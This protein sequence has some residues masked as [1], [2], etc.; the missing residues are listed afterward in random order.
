MHYILLH[1]IQFNRRTS[2]AFPKKE[3]LLDMIN[4]KSR[5]YVKQNPKFYTYNS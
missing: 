5:K 1:L 3:N 4:N 2:S